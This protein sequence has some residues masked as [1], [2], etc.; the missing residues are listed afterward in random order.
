MT[1]PSPISGGCLC[2]AVRY[3]ISAEPM[4]SGHCA[5]DNCRKGTGAEHAT[6]FA[7]AADAVELTGKTSSYAHKAD[8]GATVTRHFCPTCGSHT[9]SRNSRM[10]QMRMF[11]VG[12]LDDISR[13]TPAMFVYHARRAPWDRAGEGR[14]TFDEMP[15]ARA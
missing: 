11:P 10:E 3:T 6:I 4:M 2:G 15:P 12:T 9:F 8:S 5:C 7:V 1:T 14:Q 13:A